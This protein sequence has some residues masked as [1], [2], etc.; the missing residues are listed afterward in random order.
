MT[1]SLFTKLSDEILAPIVNQV[2]VLSAN[3]TPQTQDLSAC[4]PTAS[5]MRNADALPV[6]GG[7][8]FAGSATPVGATQTLNGGVGRFVEVFSDGGDIGVLFAANS[9]VFTGSNVANLA[10]AGV[11]TAGCCLRIPSGTYRTFFIHPASRFMNFSTGTGT[12]NVR[13][14]ATSRTG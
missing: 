1:V 9:A 8:A 7:S 5:D 11:N 13:I 3:T 6:A 4:G 2:S 14:C 12:A 10:A